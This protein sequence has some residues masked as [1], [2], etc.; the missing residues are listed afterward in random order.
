M[1]TSNYHW[2]AA[3]VAAAGVAVAAAG[4]TAFR[5]Y[6]KK[7]STRFGWRTTYAAAFAINIAAAAVPGRLDTGVP[8]GQELATLIAPSKFAFAIWGLIYAGESLGL[9]EVVGWFRL[10]MF[11]SECTGS[12]LSTPLI[13]KS[14]R[15]GTEG[16]EEAKEAAL[17][18][19]VR[20]SNNTWIGANVA[21]ALWCLTFHKELVQIGW[22]WF[23]ALMLGA[24]AALL[25]VSQR[26][27]IAASREQSTKTVALI[28]PRSIHLGWLLAAC[29]VNVNLFVANSGF[30]PSSVLATAAC[31]LVLAAVAATALL[32]QGMPGAAASLSWALYATSTGSPRG[33]KLMDEIGQATIEGLSKAELATSVCIAIA[34]LV[35][36]VKTVA[37]KV[38][39]ADSAN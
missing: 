7:V 16:S 21:Q 3:G 29:L 26:R 4:Y 23:P 38:S 15:A 20:K 25:F 22:L 8:G 6:Q 10:G 27:L 18:S 28:R 31:S 13:A 1:D 2:L 39:T 9:M 34:V 32:S 5:L 36:V 30:S 11:T 37:E 17:E 33:S 35:V 19:A 24:A 12:T 14:Q